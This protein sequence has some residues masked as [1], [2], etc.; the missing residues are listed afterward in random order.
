MRPAEGKL[1][2]VRGPRPAPWAMSLDGNVTKPKARKRPYPDL[3]R[4]KL[5]AL[6]RMLRIVDQ[7]TG[8]STRFRFTGE[9]RDVLRAMLR[10]QRV[11][12]LK[13]RQT[14]VSTVVC[15]LDLVHAMVRPNQSVAIVAHDHSNTVGLLRKCRGWCNDLGIPLLVANETRLALPNGSEVIGLTALSHSTTGD[16]KVGRSRSLHRIHVTEFSHFQRA[17]DVL[18]SLS[19]ALAPGCPLVIEATAAAGDTHYKRIWTGLDVDGNPMPGAE[20]WHRVF[21]PFE[22]H[23]AYQ[24]DPDY[25]SEDEWALAQA[26]GFTSRPHAAYWYLKLRTTK[27]N[28]RFLMQ[29]ENPLNEAMAFS[30]ALG[31][32]IHSYIG[33]TPRQEG[34][35]RF[36]AAP[37]VNDR[38]VFGLD[39]SHGVGADYAA[40]AIISHASGKL[41]ATWVNNVTPLPALEQIVIGAARTWNP[42]RVC[43]E[44]NGGKSLGEGVAQHLADARLPVHACFAHASE[45]PHRMDYVRHAIETGLIVAGPELQAEISSSTVDFRGQYHGRD[46]LINALGHALMW[47]KQNAFRPDPQAIDRTKVYVP[48]P[49]RKNSMA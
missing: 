10:H 38:P 37:D 30:A 5:L 19:D 25:L 2:F 22:A 36:Y 31:K 21:L 29:R 18:S 12:V 49:E 9:Q 39:V 16:S 26:E 17:P 11:I 6:A 1:R 23:E 8:K 3:D 45:K 46:D 43:V 14:G 35:W 13:S 40:L 33:A 47:R 48:P 41:L 44:T 42:V 15:F 7:K 34:S 28:N 24:H 4:R 32:W 20:G 27:D